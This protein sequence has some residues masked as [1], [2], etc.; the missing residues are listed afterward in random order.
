MAS[1][2]Y[3]CDC[4]QKFNRR[5]RWEQ[6]VLSL[7]RIPDFNYIALGELNINFDDVVVG[8]RISARSLLKTRRR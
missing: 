6:S 4:F 5:L 1:L 7:S 8:S 2:L 3:S